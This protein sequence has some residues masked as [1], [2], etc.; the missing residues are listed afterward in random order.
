MNKKNILTLLT[1]MVCI[2][3]SAQLASANLVTNGGFETGNFSG[4]TLGGNQG[5]TGVNPSY[6]H[7]GSYGAYLGAVG[8]DTVLSQTIATTPGETYE[9]TFWLSSPGGNTNDFSVFLAGNGPLLNLFNAGSFP[10]T[11]Y[12]FNAVATNTSLI[13]YAR[14]D[15]SFWGLD[16]ISVVPTATP[17]PATMLLLGLGLVGLAGARRKFKK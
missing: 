13:F 17:E 3:F 8:S 2:L 5:F 9:L 1:I 11:Q 14:Q 16:D 12:T 7:S 15:P 10:Y 4:W 6:A